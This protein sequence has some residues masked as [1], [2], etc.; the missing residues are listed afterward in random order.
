MNR[1]NIKTTLEDI[2]VLRNRISHN[3]PICFNI[4]NEIDYSYIKHT[5]FNTQYPK[6]D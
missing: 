1:A 4:A 3:E 5:Q 2:N 6:L